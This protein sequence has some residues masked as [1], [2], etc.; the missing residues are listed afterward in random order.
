MEGRNRLAVV[1]LVNG[2][3]SVPPTNRVRRYLSGLALPLVEGQETGMREQSRN[4]LQQQGDTLLASS[5]HHH[6]VEQAEST[7]AAGS[8]SSQ[9]GAQPGSSNL[10]VGASE[11]KGEKGPNKANILR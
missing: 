8:T 1:S 11:K 9:S 2:L 10:N 6:D 3:I 7:E 5:S 4:V